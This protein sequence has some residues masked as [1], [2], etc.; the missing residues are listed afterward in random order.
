LLPNIKLQIVPG[1]KRIRKLAIA[2]SDLLRKG[3]PDIARH[4]LRQRALAKANGTGQSQIKGPTSK[5]LKAVL[6]E[7]S[8]SEPSSSSSDEDEKTKKKSPKDTDADDRVL[9]P[10]FLHPSH[11]P[12]QMPS[13]TSDNSQLHE[14][15]V[16]SSVG[17]TR[18]VFGTIGMRGTIKI[19]GGKPPSAIGSDTRSLTQFLQDLELSALLP[20]F[21]EQ[22][23]IF[24]MLPYLENS[25]YK[26]M[27]ISIRDR[28]VIQRALAEMVSRSRVPSA[29]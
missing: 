28:M 29:I 16:G 9:P 7:A 17:N 8:M 25:D 18:A 20:R 1:N 11:A 13:F 6:D 5:Q 3:N 23:L 4:L 26:D 27:G 2:E 21:E 22:N 24:E 10:S 15:I 14:K 12:I 19:G